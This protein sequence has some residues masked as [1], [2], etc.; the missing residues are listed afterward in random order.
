MRAFVPMLLLT[1]L[2]AS[3]HPARAATPAGDAIQKGKVV[4]EKGLNYL[5]SVQQPNGAV[6]RDAREPSAI[7]ALVLKALA[8][9][10]KHGPASAPAK[11]AADYL[12]SIQQPDG[13][14]YAGMLANYNTA[15]SISALA[16][17]NDPAHKDVIAR[18][19]AFL[20]QSQ[21]TDAIAGPDGKKIGPSD[22]AF[23]G[24]GY[25]GAQGRP[26]LSNAAIAV[27]ALKDGGLDEKDPAYQNAIKFVTRMQNLS[28]TNPS[29]WATDD[30]GFIY[31]P[32]KDGSGD[33]SA[34]EYETPDGKRALR[35]YGSMT[36]AGLKSMI[37]AGLSKDDPRVQAAWKWIG[38]NWSVDEHPGM[39]A[40][41][42]PR[43][44]IFYYYH[45]LAR[46]LAVYGEPTVTDT[47]G[48]AHDW[49]IE[50]LTKLA[51]IQQPDGSF[52]GERQWME[53]N[54]VIATPLA[55]LAAQEALADLEKNPPK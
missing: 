41:G 49:R 20:K 32:G 36:Y 10:A 55:V 12:V 13:G 34:G 19:V 35:S 14:I 24:W 30:G 18:A 4:V 31:S 33:S 54:P 2:T 21:L 50:L 25:G 11:K 42:S 48:N 37:Y 44:G 3:P 51:A 45:T 26:D 6:Q 47:Q 23:G 43:A 38:S 39:A 53:S 22:P 9:D 5:S 7:T 40:A 16:S 52:V 15:I 8:Q 29:D 1:L 27:E 17:M 28:E 46:A